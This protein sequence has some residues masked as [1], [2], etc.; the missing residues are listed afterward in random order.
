MMGEGAQAP[1]TLTARTLDGQGAI[2]PL[3]FHP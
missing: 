3:M 2:P 1:R